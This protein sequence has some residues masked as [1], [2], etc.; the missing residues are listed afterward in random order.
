[1][2]RSGTH[3]YTIRTKKIEL[4]RIVTKPDVTVRSIAMMPFVPVD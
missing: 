4:R 3:I 1:M 2:V